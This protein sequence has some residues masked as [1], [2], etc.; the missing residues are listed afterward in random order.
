MAID[1]YVCMCVCQFWNVD[2]IVPVIDGGGT[3]D[4]DNLRTLC[5]VCHRQVTARQHKDRATLRRVGQST[6]ACH[7]DITAFFQRVV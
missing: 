6:A 3:C 5:T 2:H 7:R 4:V 1:R